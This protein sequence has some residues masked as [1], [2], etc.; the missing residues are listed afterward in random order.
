MDN[1][2]VNTDG[3]RASVMVHEIRTACLGKTSVGAFLQATF[4]GKLLGHCDSW[5]GRLLVMVGRW[6]R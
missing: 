4:L 5:G 3:Q 6:K 2:L 1:C